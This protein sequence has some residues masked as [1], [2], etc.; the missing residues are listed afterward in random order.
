MNGVLDQSQL[1]YM[2]IVRVAAKSTRRALL[3]HDSAIVSAGS[4]RATRRQNNGSSVRR[5]SDRNVRHS[6][7]A[8]DVR[9]LVIVPHKRMV[10]TRNLE[11]AHDIALSVALV[12]RE[13]MVRNR[14]LDAVDK[15]LET[16]EGAHWCARVFYLVCKLDRASNNEL[17]LQIVDTPHSV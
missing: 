15:E 10:T 17:P 2:I 3:A 1:S 9:L 6:G 7:D 14:R 12:N 5:A 13:R 4:S 16:V 11:R 8:N